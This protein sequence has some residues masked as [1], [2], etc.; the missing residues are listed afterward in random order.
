[1]QLFARAPWRLSSGKHVTGLFSWGWGHR[2]VMM[3]KFPQ[4]WITLASQRTMFREPLKDPNQSTMIHWCRPLAAATWLP[5]GSRTCPSPRHNDRHWGSQWPYSWH[6]GS[7]VYM[8]G[9]ASVGVLSI[10][11]SS[12]MILLTTW[13][14]LTTNLK[15]YSLE[16]DSSL[17]LFSVENT[18]REDW[19]RLKNIWAAH[20][21]MHKR[22]HKQTIDNVQ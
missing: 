10:S 14:F 15:K 13:P 5:L 2:C 16:P 18:W 21:E 20:E 17:F 1:M 9:I 19:K 11:M 4:S 6:F 8:F 12:F 22:I 3:K 7:Q